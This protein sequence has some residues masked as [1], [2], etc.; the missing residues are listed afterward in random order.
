MNVGA[1]QLSAAASDVQES[2]RQVRPAPPQ[3]SPSEDNLVRLT[4]RTQEST[5]PVSSEQDQVKVQ[6]DTSVHL[7]IYQFVNQSGALI[8]QVPSEQ[9]L[10][11]TRGIQEALQNEVLQQENAQQA[12][13]AGNAGAKSNGD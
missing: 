7:R 13:A 8:L 2:A 5:P 12:E 9:V 4:Q 10:G 6:W 3:R 1:A 11:V